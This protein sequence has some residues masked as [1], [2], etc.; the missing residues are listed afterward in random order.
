LALFVLF[1][2]LYLGQC[3]NTFLKYVAKR[4]KG[5][6]R[7]P[8]TVE[9]HF[10]E[11]SQ[12][13]TTTNAK[14]SFP[15]WTKIAIFIMLLPAAYF[16]LFGLYDKDS[17]FSSEVREQYVPAISEDVQLKGTWV[18]PSANVAS[19]EIGNDVMREYYVYGGEDI[20][21]IVSIN[22]SQIKIINRQTK[23][24]Y[25]IRYKLEKDGLVL[26]Y[27]SNRVGTFTRMN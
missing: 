27:S 24:R 16:I 18:G 23:E 2:L 7:M 8:E 17:E 6:R 4:T 21:D 12:Q 11:K 5:V 22:G 26:M 15:V 10:R 25:R 3:V 1:Y 20:S 14:P 19:I 13:N 9:K